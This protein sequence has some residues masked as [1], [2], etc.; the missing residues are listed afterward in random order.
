MYLE[1]EHQPP[2]LVDGNGITK[3]AATDP[4]LGVLSGV[5]HPAKQFSIKN[6][7]LFLYTDGL[8]EGRLKKGEKKNLGKE[9]GLKGFLR[10]LLQSGKMPINEQMTWI[11]EQCISQLAPQSDDLTL[12]II[13]GE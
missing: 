2:F 6:S 7:R 10:W 8:T 13:S 11:K 5:L 3:I 1:R 12:M 4:P 9:L